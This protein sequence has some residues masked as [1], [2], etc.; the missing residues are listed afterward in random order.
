MSHEN[1][2]R[3]WFIR[4][5]SLGNLIIALPMVGAMFV[6]YGRWAV[7][8]ATVERHTSQLQK[9]EETQ[10]AIALTLAELKTMVDERTVKDG[11]AVPREGSPRESTK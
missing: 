2:K 9:S 11:I 10:E 5:V 7:M 4:E 1:P 8:E 6:G 3:S